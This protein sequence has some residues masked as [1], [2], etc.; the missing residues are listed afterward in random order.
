MKIMVQVLIILVLTIQIIITTIIVIHKL[1]IL[2]HFYA[3]RNEHVT[4]IAQLTIF[5]YIGSNR[6]IE[7]AL[8]PKFINLM[9]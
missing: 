1:K 4:L 6:E 7:N 3:I 9:Q 2:L 5:P 8:D